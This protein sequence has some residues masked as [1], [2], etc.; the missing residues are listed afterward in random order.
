MKKWIGAAVA[1]LFFV[2]LLAFL[3]PIL[4]WQKQ[5]DQESAE[6]EA[7]S[8][9]VQL[10]QASEPP[11][12]TPSE[13]DSS[14]L[15][16]LISSLDG[17][18]LSEDIPASSAPARTS[19][20]DL[21]ACKAQNSD[22]AAWLSIPNTPV[23]YPVVFTYDTA[24]Y[25]KH[26]FTGSTSSLGTLFATGDTSFNQP[27]RNI[28]IY[29][30]NIRSKP[31]V[32]F[33][34]LL[35]YKKAAFYQAHR[36]IHLDTLNGAYIYKVFAAFNMR[37]DDFAPEKA[38]FETED[39]FARFMDFV[40]SASLHEN[41]MTVTGDDHLLTLITCDRTYGGADGRFVVMAVREDL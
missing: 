32:M 4:G 34:P 25:L 41:D 33:S 38:D 22:F 10:P 8:S 17:D 31:T 35:S 23:N 27:S 24:Y 11:V 13:A 39:D 3:L 6:Y 37:Y 40:K 9:A 21:E 19:S 28:A 15:N 7:L 20:I 1:L 36:T 18:V 30:H 12:A 2:G 16:D 29:G 26:S 14:V 5:L